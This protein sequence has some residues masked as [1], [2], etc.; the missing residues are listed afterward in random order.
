MTRRQMS[1][2]LL[3]EFDV[4]FASASACRC[5]PQVTRTRYRSRSRRLAGLAAFY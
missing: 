2:L 5:A 4:E 3:K 1:G